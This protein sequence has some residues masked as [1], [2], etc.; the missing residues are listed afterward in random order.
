MTNN[1]PISQFIIH[2]INK[3]VKGKTKKLAVNKIFFD[4]KILSSA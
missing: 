1:V 2:L 3:I 4:D